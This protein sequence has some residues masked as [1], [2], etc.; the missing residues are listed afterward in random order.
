M[1]GRSIECTH[2]KLTSSTEGRRAT[3]HYGLEE[4]R[5]VNM[6]N[7]SPSLQQCPAKNWF[8]PESSTRIGI[9]LVLAVEKKL[10]SEKKVLCDSGWVP[11]AQMLE[12]KKVTEDTI[13][14]TLQDLAQ[15]V[16]K[17]AIDIDP[18]LQQTAA[19]QSSGTQPGTS[20]V[21]GPS[22]KPDARSILLACKVPKEWADGTIHIPR[23]PSEAEWKKK[24]ADGKPI[25]LLNAHC[26]ATGEFKKVAS[27][28]AQS[29]NER[30]VVGGASFVIYNDPRR[31][32]IFSITIE[33]CVTRLW[34][35]D[36]ANAVVSNP[37]DCH[38]SPLFLIR[39][40]LLVTFSSQQ[41]LGYDSLVQRHET[42]ADGPYFIFS[43]GSRRFR[44]KGP[45]LY[46]A[47]AALL[48]SRGVRAWLVDEIDEEGHI[49]GENM[50]LK[51]YWVFDDLPTE[52]DIQQEILAA[53][54]ILDAAEGRSGPSSRVERMKKYF[55]TI[56]LEVDV[57]LEDET[58]DKT[59]PAPCGA[60]DWSF[61]R[62]E[63]APRDAPLKSTASSDPALDDPL[64]KEAVTH[65]HHL[66]KLHRRVVYEQHCTTFYDQQNPR[67]VLN[68]LMG[69]VDALDLLREAGFVHRDISG[70]NC[71]VYKDPGT[72][73]LCAKL[74]DLEYCKPVSK[75]GVHDPI[76]TTREFL[77]VEPSR[78]D[79]LFE[80]PGL[81]QT[82]ADYY[83]IPWH[84]L[85][86]LYWL[87]VYWIISHFPVLSDQD[88][89]RRLVTLKTQKVKWRQH[90]TDYFASENPDSRRR[91]LKEPFDVN[92]LSKMGWA[93][94]TLEILRPV[95]EFG[96][97]L[98]QA[99]CDLETRRQKY[100]PDDLY[101]LRWPRKHFTREPYEEFY[102][103]L[104]EARNNISDS[105]AFPSV[106]S[107]I[108]DPNTPIPALPIP[109]SSGQGLDN[110]PGVRTRFEEHVP[111]LNSSNTRWN[112]LHP[113]DDDD[114]FQ[115]EDH[116]DEGQPE[117]ATTSLDSPDHGIEAS[118]RGKELKIDDRPFGWD[119]E[120][121]DWLY[122]PNDPNFGN[123]GNSLAPAQNIT[124]PSSQP[125]TSGRKRKIV[126]ETD[127]EWRVQP[128]DGATG[129]RQQASPTV[130]PSGPKRPQ[131]AKKRGH[132][133]VAGPSNTPS[134]KRLK[135]AGEKETGSDRQA[136]PPA[137]STSSGTRS[138]P[139][140]H[141]QG[142]VASLPENS[143][144]KSSRRSRPKRP[145]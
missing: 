93:F 108:R 16:A 100:H 140:K 96:T 125:Q 42:A 88:D 94:G 17:A 118:R 46:D 142:Q 57:L 12:K 65:T 54:A 25:S 85:E 104:K 30:Q 91:L 60:A 52:E 107:L 19:W 81:R 89:N 34:R 55:L 128:N 143:R 45:P 112:L 106:F 10:L 134:S 98:G 63:A 13:Y 6:E 26:A 145:S 73:E 66:R 103:R 74:T 95:L 23:Q 27:L 141:G 67:N 136:S 32:F 21:P 78:G 101:T 113:T 11:L 102:Q 51:D 83:Y 36:R 50:V 121:E 22:L 86:A 119:L 7:V 116:G 18:T 58:V 133:Q 129:S 43:V 82:R 92:T 35:F 110:S 29:Q 15:T 44:T 47:G 68:L 144:S 38:K 39:F 120:L 41:S 40:L 77:A 124:P 59:P 132:G 79:L 90:Y 122:V 2:F 130:P 33:K 126:L 99:Y 3:L 61:S 20:D 76:S 87:A 137:A 28:G 69:F 9:Q 109:H 14:G 5:E 114:L 37:F 64:R 80:P 138:S 31:R 24:L 62:T 97:V 127:E 135:S 131:S 71:L 115:G 72:G 117:E 123:F 70:G 139:R 49:I 84:D 75:I 56:L 111:S 53:L 48:I 8:P 4:I 105:S 1:R